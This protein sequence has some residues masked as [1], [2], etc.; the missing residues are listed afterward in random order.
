MVDLDALYATICAASA[1]SNQRR[2][3][4]KKRNSFLGKCVEI[5]KQKKDSFVSGEIHGL[6]QGWGVEP[7]RAWY[8]VSSSVF[9]EPLRLD[10]AQLRCLRDTRVLLKGDEAALKRFA[11]YMNKFK[12][13]IELIFQFKNYVEQE[14]LVYGFYYRVKT[15]YD[16]FWSSMNHLLELCQTFLTRKKKEDQEQLMD[17]TIL[18]RDIQEQLDAVCSELEACLDEED[19]L[20]ASLLRDHFTEEDEHESILA[21]ISC[22]IKWTTNE[23][24]AIEKIAQAMYHWLGVEGR[25]VFMNCLSGA[26]R[27]I[28]QSKTAK[29]LADYN[30]MIKCIY[31]PEHE[32]I[33][34]AQNVLNKAPS[35]RSLA[36]L[37]FTPRHDAMTTPYSTKYNEFTM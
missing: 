28:L 5:A 32:T 3:K 33:P 36:K 11:A 16:D 35:K 13:H 18:L 4:L 6:P 7:N 25:R 9:H 37:L 23:P 20:L 14:R 26:I 29:E 1:G 15:N 31:A 22:S 19:G 21:A 24:L 8:Q 17:E 27:C 12:K 34:A 30:H 2:S 10:I